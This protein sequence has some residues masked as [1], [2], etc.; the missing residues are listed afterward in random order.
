MMSEADLLGRKSLVKITEIPKE[1][2]QTPLQDPML[3]YRVCQNLES[4]C[5]S[6]GGIGLAAVQVG[7]PWNLF[8]VKS[9]GNCPLIHAKQYGYFANCEYEPAT[10]EQVVSLEGCLSVRSYDG[11]LRLFQV[12]RFIKIHLIGF[13]L[14]FDEN[15]PG[16]KPIDVGVKFQEQGVVFQHEIDHA[17]AKLISD[18]GK[19]VFVW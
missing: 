16:F 9:D 1:V 7:I 5:E 14:V 4:L 17:K 12:N 3:I 8:V 18:I 6:A 19:E 15:K 10:E 2:E 11:Q 13:Q